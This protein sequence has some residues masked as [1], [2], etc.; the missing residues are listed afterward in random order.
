MRISID[1]MGGDYAPA[2]IVAGTLRAA[3]ELSG[4]SKLYLVGDESAIHAELD[5]HKG[6]I[7]QSI[8]IVHASQVVEMGESPAVAIRRKK[9][10]SIGRAVDLVKKGDADAIFSAG[11]TGAAVAA[12]TLKLRTLAGVDR[13]AIA[14][15]LPSP[16][17]PFVLLDAGA[18][19]DSTS[20]MLQQYAVMG[21]IY[22]REILGIKNPSV[23]LLSIGEEDAK[24][25]EMTKKTFAMLSASHLNFIGNVESRDMFEARVNVVVC[26]GFVGNVVLKTT[27]SVGRMMS[28]WLNEEFRKTPLRM[29]GGLLG[30]G[31]FSYM[32]NKCDPS[33]YGGAPLLGANGVVI[34]GHGSSNTLAVLN[35]VRVATE[36]IDHH[37]NHLIEDELKSIQPRT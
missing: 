18:N 23:G 28:V 11:N 5:K 21:S 30:R 34:I 8:E 22:S 15:I 12:A 19:P 25:N 6:S 13:P 36:T 26:D 7:P 3:T 4:I 24:G 32:R 20:A 35:A 27:E 31:A 9:D 37:V 2:E 17:D 10:S 33:N 1:A 29:L 14:T 16:K